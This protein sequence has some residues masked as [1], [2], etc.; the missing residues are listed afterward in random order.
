MFS[1][2]LTMTACAATESSPRAK[3]L[4]A[5]A[6][7]YGVVRW[8]YPGDETQKVDW[9]SLA[10]S[11]VKAVERART[12]EELEETLQSIFCPIAPGVA[13]TANPN[14][15]IDAIM[16]KNTA[17]MREIAWQHYGVDLGRWSNAYISKRTYRGTA[18][19]GLNRLVIEKTLPAIEYIG[20]DLTLSVAIEN[21][22]PSTLGVFA[23]IAIVDSTPE[24][25]IDFCDF[26][27]ACRLNREFRKKI[28][29]DESASDKLIRVGIYT[30]GV[31]EFQIKACS[32]AA[33]NPTKPSA[34]P[35]VSIID[36]PEISAARNEMLYDYALS[37]NACFV[38]TKNLLFDEHAH[39]GD[40]KRIELV[41]GLYAHVPLALYGDAAATYPLA[42][43]APVGKARPA[44]EEGAS[45]RH[46]MLADLIVTWNVIKYFHPYLADE[47]KDWD[48]CLLSAIEE[49]TACN[50][51]SLDPLRRMMSNVNDAHF[52]AESPLE[53][54]D[55]DFL[56]FRV[57]KERGRIIVTK[58]LDASIQPGDEIVRVG[59]ADAMARYEECEKL[60]SGSPQYKA[61]I[62][63][64]IWLRQHDKAPEILLLRKGERF[65]R[66]IESIRRQT[67]INRLLIT[68]DIKKSR[69]IARDTL[70]INTGFASL[71]EIKSLLATRESHQTVLID[72]RDG[73]NFLLKEILP[74]IAPKSCFLPRRTGI[75]R[76]P[77]TYLP[78]S[79]SL[80]DTLE[81]VAPPPLKCKNVFVTGPMNFSN[82]EETVDYAIYCGVAKTAG[83]ATAGCNGRINKIPLPSGGTVAFTGTKVYSNLGKQGYYYGKGIP[84]R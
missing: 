33:T 81:S 21:K 72:I 84:V 41:D 63:E 70:Y 80:K 53:K 76:I 57:K 22:T 28:H 78:L 55:Y 20:T 12:V 74:Y 38:A 9:D 34:N 13:V 11:G 46:Q 60:V 65:R 43:D 49:A 10:L 67:F 17:G 14:Y 35:S 3:Y 68:S 39:V 26:T 58:S 83:E 50:G 7:T 4:K 37:G 25:Y 73:S 51:Y 48:G 47:V 61:Y 2:A 69:W 27:P 19:Q 40:V 54:K 5:F 71:S 23:K 32:L 18:S 66:K 42:S 44:S 45:E 62:A 29:V 30:E 6:E 31:G 8:F 56:P 59:S 77:K 52:I 24:A 36:L 16:P 79:P 75:S 1:F 64:R 15:D 82:H